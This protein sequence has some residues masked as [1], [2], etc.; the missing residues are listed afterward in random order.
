M[1][2]DDEGVRRPGRTGSPAHSNANDSG[3]ENHTGGNPMDEDDDADLFGSDGEGGLDDLNNDHRS[4]NDEQLDSGDDEG[5]YDRR[6]DRMDE[7]PDEEQIF[8]VQDLDLARAPVPATNDGEVYSMR[9]PDFLSVEAEEFNPATYVPPP[10]SQAATSL[11]WRK[12]P[13]NDALLQS[14]ARM[15]RWEDGSVTLQLASAPLEQYRIASKSLAPLNKA[16]QYD[17]K[18]DSHVYLAAGLE[19][20]QVFRL[21]SHVTHGLTIL[22]TTLET[23]DA[24][25][26]LQES[27]A[28]AARGS[29]QTADGSAPI[30]D[31]KEDPELATR[32]AELMEKEAIKAERR[33][34]QLADREADRGRR[35]G[36][37][38]SHGT[39]LSVGAL[40]DGGLLT[41]RPRAKP[42]R[43]NRR[44]EI[45][46]DD[47]EDYS[48]GARNREDEY[49]ED[50]GFLVG[51][52]ED[53]EEEEV[54]DEEEELEDEDMDAEGE[55]DDEVAPAKAAR[56]KPAP[57]P[58]GRSET[59]PA[60]RKKNR[61]V[62]DDEDDE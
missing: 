27:L 46:S 12:D 25:Q 19:A 14:N 2:S 45:Y 41:T 8:N 44:G 36:A 34:Q 43:Q 11:C 15:I 40:E 24:V 56:S 13:E 59:P 39:G 58:Q 42:R 28:A 31:T 60:A 52:D 53:I 62:V 23:D 22:P 57:K 21:T 54:D 1:S 49:D 26:R 38:R 7:A 29:K 3:A 61:Y 35:A 4:I 20:A 10:Y 55:A 9:V 32:R 5:R 17:T 6:E 33:R 16:G 48:R 50:D 51:S 37:P 18:L 47:E 30:V